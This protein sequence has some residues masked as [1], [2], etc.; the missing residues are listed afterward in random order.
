MK[1]PSRPDIVYPVRKGD[2]NEELRFSLRSLSNL[3][4]NRVWIVGHKPKWVKERSGSSP[5]VY[6]IPR[7]QRATKYRNANESLVEVARELGS[8]MSSPFLLMNDD[9]YIM[10]PRKEIGPFHMGP[11][12]EVINRYRKLHHMGAYW[13][14]MVET[15]RLMQALKIRAPLSYELHIPF[16]VY[17]DYVLEAWEKGKHLEVLHIRTLMGNLGRIGGEQMDDVKVYRGK[18]KDYES[19]PFLSSNDDMTLTPL[20]TLLR[21]RFPN[22]SPYEVGG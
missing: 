22:P 1:N 21:T 3:P 19:W 11:V 14:G 20:R 10:E 5:G 13:R 12:E 2:H 16:P 9:F 6:F 7:E 18:T 17:R 4:H 15:W 8:S